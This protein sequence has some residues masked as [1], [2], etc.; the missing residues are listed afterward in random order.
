[1][2]SV[3]LTISELRREKGVTQSELA[4][5][6]GVSFQAV[7]KWE[8]GIS[9][10]DIIL[11][12]LLS[13]YF[14]VSVDEIL[15]LKPLSNREYIERGTDKKEHW[16]KKLGYLKDSRIGFW[17]E[18]YLEFLVNKVWNITK[19][20]DIID[21]GCGYGYL[22]IMLLKI[23]PTGSTYTG[24]DISDKLLDEAR[25]IF[26]DSAYK[27]K[28]IKSDLNS[29]KVKEKYDIAICQALL[30]HL[31]NPKEILKKMTDSVKIGGM[32]I[33]AEINREFENVGLYI[34]GIEY[35]SL[36]KT[37]V[38][39]KFWKTELELEGRDYSVGIKVPC[40]MQECGL[41]NIDVRINDKVNL[42]NPYEDKS[43]Y[44][45]L[46]NS[47]ITTNEWNRIL[48]EDE[49]KDI[50][51]LFM[52]RGLTRTEAEIYLK[53]EMDICQFIMNNKDDAFILKT[54]CL[55]I[56]YGTK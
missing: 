11:L 31:P 1:M 38:L 40:Y 18:D 27:T 43:K 50:I 4:D 10:P 47:L 21:F 12:P 23:L 19:P 36:N 5:Y 25:I 14:Q 13:E 48:S 32:V 41:H 55:L 26:K 15:G 49:K 8:N 3:K 22:G 20:I 33:C 17:N 37:S 54:H 24:V 2:K 56:S 30:R 51:A 7:S 44:S 6:L 28:F 52:N 42:I 46:L 9:M 34:K 39:K 53:S 16:D 29:L 35:N 45:K